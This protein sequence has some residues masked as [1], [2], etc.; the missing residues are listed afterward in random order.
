MLRLVA[1]KSKRLKRNTGTVLLF[2]NKHGEARGR[3][4]HFEINMGTETK[5]P[6]P[7][8]TPPLS[9]IVNKEIDIEM[10]QYII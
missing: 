8:P 10:S 5:G 2:R 4:F 7:Y 9:H 1:I 3:S 6:S